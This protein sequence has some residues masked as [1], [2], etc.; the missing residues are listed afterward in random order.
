MKDFIEYFIDYITIEKDASP[1]TIHKY[2]A[3]LTRFQDYLKIN[4]GLPGLNNIKLGHI[5]S[6]LYHLKESYSYRSSSL[7]N[8]INIIKHFF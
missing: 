2:R 4:L 3:D 5:R 6:Y 8:K 1:R 7:A